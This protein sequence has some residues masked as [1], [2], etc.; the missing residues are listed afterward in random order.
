VEFHSRSGAQNTDR[1]GLSF[2]HRGA[3]TAGVG[4]AD[5]FSSVRASSEPCSTHPNA[6]QK[7]YKAMIDQGQW[8]DRGLKC[9]G[10]VVCRVENLRPLFDPQIA[11]DDKHVYF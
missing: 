1:H 4:M 11:N 10:D 7:F 2:G 6:W 5:H 8:L 3:G 9:C